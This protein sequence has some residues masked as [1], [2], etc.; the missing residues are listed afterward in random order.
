MR[1]ENKLHTY[2]TVTQRTDGF[3]SL[4][5]VVNKAAE[6]SIRMFSFFSSFLWSVQVSYPAS[7]FIFSADS[8]IDEQ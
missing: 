8:G 5:Y 4:D 7:R 2:E 1:I 3:E 6:I